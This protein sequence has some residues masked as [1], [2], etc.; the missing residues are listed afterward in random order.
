MEQE[1]RSALASRPARHAALALAMAAWTAAAQSGQPVAEKVFEVVGQVVDA[2]S[3]VALEG[4]RVLARPEGTPAS[5][6]TGVD[7]RFRIVFP[8]P[9]QFELKLDSAELFLVGSMA[10]NLEALRGA[11]SEQTPRVTRRLALAREGQISG[12]LLDEETA[13]P[14]AGLHV[15]AYRVERRAG[16]RGLLPQKSSVGSGS[17][18]RFTLPGLPPGEYLI[19]VEQRDRNARAIRTKFTEAEFEKSPL[20]Y[21]RSFWPGNGGA[22]TA[23]PLRLASG[24]RVGV[25]D[26]RLSRQP[27]PRLR[28][29]LRV[30]GCAA[31]WRF[32]VNV[33][34][35]FNG[36]HMDRVQGTVGCEGEFLVEW[37]EPGPFRLLVLPGQDAP[38]VF[39][40]QEFELGRRDL[41]LKV[42][43]LPGLSVRGRIVM[44]RGN[45]PDPLQLRMRLVG[46]TFLPVAKPAT[47]AWD[48][49]RRAGA[50]QL[51]N[52]QPGTQ[53]LRFA[54]LPAGHYVSRLVYNGQAASEWAIPIDPYALEHQVEIT[55]GNE[56]ASLRGVV[57]ER[58]EAVAEALVVLVPEG[59]SGAARY[60]A[61]RR[62]ASEADGR[63]ELRQLTPGD[64][65]LLAV[66]G[67][68][69]ERL[70][71]GLVL[72]SLLKRAKAV[73]LGR[74]SAQDIKLEVL[75]GW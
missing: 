18:G 37:L 1:T 20:H 64:Y 6:T 62:A 30:P 13:Q 57:Q 47:V 17:D 31:H 34:Q 14:L 39:A 66:P 25:G 41:T 22:E 40:Q 32:G 75:T 74:G 21:P 3:G 68:S 27:A 33:V 43:V 51:D 5:I 4:V 44:E 9:T 48:D 29:Q 55:L 24:A 63:F 65:R 60:A 46:R 58:T 23:L 45:A 2:E 36:L 7:G 10:Q 35:S 15:Q 16:E 52:L 49:Q 42:D 67:G 73:T 72:D 53:E 28:A 50:F 26:L 70:E 59:A 8:G 11:V 61:Q 69:A 71:D 12:R 38:A 19:Q 54:G 56:P